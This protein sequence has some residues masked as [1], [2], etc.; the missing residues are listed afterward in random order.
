MTDPPKLADG[1]K[2]S[3]LIGNR[4]PWGH[5]FLTLVFSA[6]QGLLG[7]WLIGFVVH[8]IGTWPGPDYRELEKR[9]LDQAVVGQAE[10]NQQ[11]IEE[12]ESRIRDQKTRQDLLRDSTANSQRTMN[13]L[14]D[15][16]RLSLEKD[17]TPSADEQRALAESQQRFLAN[18][19]E[20]QILNEAIVK[21]NEQLRSL[22]ND[23]RALQ[24]RLGDLRAVIRV[25]HNELRRKY[26]LKI[27]TLKLAVLIPLAL[28]AVV[29]ALRM[30]GG[31]YA[32]LAYALCI[33]VLLKVGIVMHEHFPTRY[34]KYLFI[35]AALAVVL[36]ILIY[37]VS[38][39][40]RPKQQWLLKQYREAYESFLCP[41]CAY[42]IRQ[43]PLR[44][45]A[46]TRRSIKKMAARSPLTA[47]EDQPYI[48]PLCSTPLYEVCEACGSV[49]HSLLPTC[50]KCGHTK[51][52]GLADTT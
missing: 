16:Q 35:L 42:P 1:H 32:P 34:F 3:P 20:Y 19:R 12:T 4:G 37:L 46:W 44:F 33:A 36:R 47:E 21:I 27:A 13:Q 40:K 7:F 43:G 31:S 10:S 41:I 2:R 23:Q 50:V 38:M 24:G 14:L 9:M 48:C 45:M 17:V 15:F 28:M 49:R 52:I 51:L 26:Q 29:F 30:R 8:D 25:E 11:Q 39:V 6:L 22:Q 5:R 18:Q